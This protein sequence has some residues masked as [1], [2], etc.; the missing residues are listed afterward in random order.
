ML[1]SIRLHKRGFCSLLAGVLHLT[2]NSTIYAGQGWCPYPTQK[3]GTRAGGGSL[4]L[5]WSH[6]I[7]QCGLKICDT[8]HSFLQ[9]PFGR[10]YQTI[11]IYPVEQ[12]VLSLLCFDYMC[13]RGFKLHLSLLPFTQKITSDNDRSQRNIPIK[14][15]I[16]QIT[17]CWA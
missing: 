15:L 2:S 6:Y 11:L 17:L 13:E 8:S 1:V 10:Q 9:S 12:N 16:W 14:Q 3:D 4:F 5:R 7:N